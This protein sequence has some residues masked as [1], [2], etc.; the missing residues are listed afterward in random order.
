MCGPKAPV[1][2]AAV[3]AWVSTASVVIG[4]RRRVLGIDG[5]LVAAPVMA[6]GGDDAR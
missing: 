4:R 2:A 3:V 5:R 6:G 1:G